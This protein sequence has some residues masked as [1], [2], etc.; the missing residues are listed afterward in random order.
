ML[1]PKPSSS[2]TRTFCMKPQPHCR[3]SLRSPVPSAP[4]PCVPSSGGVTTTRGLAAGEPSGDGAR[5]SVPLPLLL[6]VCPCS[7]LWLWCLLCAC[8]T[9]LGSG[10]TA[11]VGVPVGVLPPL[12]SSLVSLQI[13]A[14]SS[15]SSR[16]RP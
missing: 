15:M 7:W 10:G 11:A 16:E 6:R 14:E 8:T 2:T 9:P 13:S 12:L 3:P 4:A 5:A 1:L